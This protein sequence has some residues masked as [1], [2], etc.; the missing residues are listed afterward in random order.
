MTKPRTVYIYVPGILTKPGEAKNWCGRAVTR[1][2]LDHPGVCAEKVEYWT[3]ALL[4]PIGQKGRADKL[5]K[6]LHYYRAAGWRIVLVGHS[7]G[8]D[9]ILDALR[10]MG[11]PR[12]EAL[13]LVS[14]ACEADF[15]KNGLN[16]FG[17]SIGRIVVYIAGK[18]FALRMAGWLPGR[19]LG[20]GVLGKVGPQNVR[21]GLKIAIIRE[22]LYGH[23]DWFTDANFQG[24]MELLTLGA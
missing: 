8:C 20:Y 14:A 2:H 11:W 16:E 23:S 9:V 17:S 22:P 6:V 19:W 10:D 13:H 24:T 21:A 12:I 1:T 4:R 18:D 15:R 3:R 5:A 7:N